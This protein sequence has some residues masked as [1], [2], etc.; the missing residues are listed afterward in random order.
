[1]RNPAEQAEFFKV[2]SKLLYYLVTGQSYVGYLA[3][4]K[5]NKYYI[6]GEQ[7]K[8]RELVTEAVKTENILPEVCTERFSSR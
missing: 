8:R 3:A 1:M 2:L 7:L 5:W 6:L 4:Q